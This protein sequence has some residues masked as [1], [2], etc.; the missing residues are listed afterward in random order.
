MVGWLSM[1]L[2]QQAEAFSHRWY[3]DRLNFACFIAM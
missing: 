2:F 1:V 3:V